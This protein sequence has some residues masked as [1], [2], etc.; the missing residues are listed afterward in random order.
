MRTA[1]RW[2]PLAALL[3]LAGCERNPVSPDDFTPRSNV[4]IRDPRMFAPIAVE[5]PRWLVLRD[6]GLYNDQ[7]RRRLSRQRV[8]A[9]HIDKAFELHRRVKLGLLTQ[10]PAR[11]AAARAISSGAPKSGTAIEVGSPSRAF[12]PNLTLRP[13]TAPRLAVAADDPCFFDATIWCANELGGELGTGASGGVWRRPG[14]SSSRRR[15]S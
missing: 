14:R 13:P 10:K 2:I 9:L 1:T 6:D 4:V 15:Y 7:G 8:N 5:A 3:V 12:R 11:T